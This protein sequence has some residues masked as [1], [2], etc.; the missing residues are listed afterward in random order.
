MFRIRLMSGSSRTSF[1]KRI[2]RRPAL[3]RRSLRMLCRSLT[4]KRSPVASLS[5]QCGE[6][7]FLPSIRH[8]LLPMHR[9]SWSPPPCR[10]HYSKA[11]PCGL[12]IR[13]QD[14][15]RCRWSCHAA[16]YAVKPC[17][18]GPSGPRSSMRGVRA[19]SPPSRPLHRACPWQTSRP[20]SWARRA[21]GTTLP[22]LGRPTG[23][24][25]SYPRS[26]CGSG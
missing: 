1:R 6:N 8:L 11:R 10:L 3:R 12:A 5:T 16:R 4:S 7:M 2:S 15:R 24:P 19:A 21:S 18:S 9:P 23:P 20:S 17:G 14:H 22:E 25:R 26:A 13:K